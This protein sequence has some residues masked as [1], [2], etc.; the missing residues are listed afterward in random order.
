M[1]VGTVSPTPLNT[2]GKKPIENAFSHT[3]RE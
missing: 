1:V 2:N 3:E